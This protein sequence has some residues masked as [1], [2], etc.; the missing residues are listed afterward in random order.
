MTAAI[1]RCAKTGGTPP[2]APRNRH[3]ADG[4]RSNCMNRDQAV[5]IKEKA[6]AAV[7]ELASVLDIVKDKVPAEEFERIKKGV[8]L[9]IGSIEMHVN[10]Q[11]YRQYP[12]LAP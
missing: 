7:E 4:L 12:D 11:F 8:G 6:L 10:A 1:F 3:L 5:R 9:A 2:Q